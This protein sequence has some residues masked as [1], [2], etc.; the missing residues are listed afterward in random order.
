MPQPTFELAP[1]YRPREVEA[2]LYARWVE[3]GLFAPRADG[4]PYV[5][6]M[7]P[8]NITAVLHTGQGLNNVIQDVLIR[9]ER[10]RGRATLW[11]PGTDHAGIATQNVVERLVAKEGTTRF[12]LGREKFVERVWAFVRETG[13]TILE[14]LKVIGSSCDWSRTRFT[15][16]EAYSRAVREVFVTL[17]E[18]QLIYRGHR[19]IHWCPRCLTAL[20]DEEA[21]SKE[22]TGNLYYIRYPVEG[23]P[24]PFLTVATTRPETLLGDTA[25]AVSPKDKRHRGFVGKTARLPLTNLAIPIVADDAVDPKFGTG[26]VKVTPAHDPNDF[27]IGLRHGL[28]MP[29]VMT[30]DGRMG[31]PVGQSDGRTV[32]PRVPQ[33]LQGVDRFEAR[34]KIV[35]M[36]K[37]QGLLE[38]VEPHQHAV[39]H[40]YRCGTVVEPRLSDQWFVKMKPLAEPVLAAYRDARF[41]IVPERWH[42]TFE[43]WMEN[44][45]DWNIS[46]QLWWGHRIPV[47]TC[48]KCKHTWADR[49]DPKACPKCGGPVEQD[50]DVLDTWFSSWLWPFATLGWPERTADLARFYP[51]HTL[52]TAPEILFFW[53]ARML[54]SGYHFMDRRLPFATV[55]LHGTVRDTQHRKMSKSLGNGIDPLDVVRLFGADALRWTLI[56]GS[57]LGADVI[58]DPADLETAFAPGRNF[59][60]KLWNIGRFMLSQLPER[61]PPIEA[62]DAPA[63]PLADRWILSRLQRTIGEATA[64]LE[65]FR[66]DEAAKVCYEFA[67]KELADWYVEAVKPR[68]AARGADAEAA[69]AVLAYCFDSALRLL[70]PVVPFITEELWQ[71]L[72]G[73]AADELLAAAAWP[74]PRAELANAT[75]D[76]QF[77]RV[78]EVI[79]AIRNIR[80]EY[81]V[82]PKAR[83]AATVTTRNDAARRVLVGERETILRL[84]QLAE[85]SLDGKAGGG[86]PGGPGGHAVL[87][88]GSAVFVPLGGAIDVQQECRRLSSEATRLDQQLAA[89]AAKLTNENFVARAPAEV[90]ARERDKEQAWRNQRGVL[91]EKL[92]ALG[93]S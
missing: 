6:V 31:E 64:Q 25:V 65:Q 52:V 20:S 72:P 34:K 40:C 79:S 17:W 24:A 56:A 2:P 68:L 46:R 83:I 10:M 87:R 22:I 12:D 50:P 3:S 54:M 48:T 84:A 57:S 78:Q 28:A 61:V 59:A 5:I 8:P 15:F 82:A 27:E 92:K 39:R 67:W 33:E 29:L 70:H 35:A 76:T 49:E 13:T 32:G 73:R 80:A 62:L 9:F 1:Q 19:V 45:R 86:D 18:Q 77:A 66:L 14:Q 58:L 43:H 91:A 7:P 21:E 47:F 63:R 51:G 37:A 85:L 88:D 74:R 55:Y 4:E 41:T 38:K 69:Q 23:G 60:N 16:D 30:E 11:L 93:C 90:V 44:I 75:A 89:L 71:K 36:L 42:A 26:F 81:R 53:V